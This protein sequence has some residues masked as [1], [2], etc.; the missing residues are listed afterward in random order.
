ML[1]QEILRETKVKKQQ[2]AILKI[3]FE[4]AYD[5]VNWNFLLDCY[6]QKGFSEK[7][8]TWISNAVTGGTLSVKVNDCVG[9]YFASYKGVRQGD[10][11]APSLFNVA[12]NCLAKMISIAQQNGLILGLADHVIDGGCAILQYADD[13]I[14]LIKD[15]IECAKNLKLLL[16]TFE[17]MSGLKIN[18]EKSEVLLIQDDE[19]KLLFFADLFNCQIGSWPIK[20]LG[21]PVCAR[22]TTVAEMKFVEER[23][24]QGMEGWMGG[25]MSIGGRVTKIEACLSTSAVYQMSMHL[26]HKSNIEGMEKTHQIL[27]LGKLQREKKVSLG[28]MEADMYSKK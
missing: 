2:G 19:E 24:Q 20:Y 5:K 10:P 1:L 8:L 11:F 15:D 16:Y 25:A 12:V 13:T 9:P 4:K 17:S 23:V 28:E 14:L 18:F 3:D 26:L 6:R 22:R 7:W 27:S 21:T